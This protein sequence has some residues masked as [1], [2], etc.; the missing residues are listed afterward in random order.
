[1]HLLVELATNPGLQTV[2]VAASE[3][4]M[5]LLS[6]HEMQD[7]ELGTSPAAHEVQLVGNT[8]HYRQEDEQRLQLPEFR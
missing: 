4:D 1:M 7:P 8:E 3:Q 6:S 5:Q 2:H